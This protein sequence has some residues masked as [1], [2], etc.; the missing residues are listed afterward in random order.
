MLVWAFRA[1]ASSRYMLAPIILVV[2][3]YG[4][5]PFSMNPH[6]GGFGADNSSK[7][8]KHSEEPLMK[9]FVKKCTYT[10]KYA[11]PICIHIMLQTHQGEMGELLFLA[12]DRAHA[13]GIQIFLHTIVRTVSS[14]VCVLFWWKCSTSPTFSPPVCTYTSSSTVRL[15]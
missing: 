10:Y 1:C 8:P 13:K 14:S 2:E 7:N 11:T 3:M 9:Y 6:W 4:W 5:F 15:L 12:K